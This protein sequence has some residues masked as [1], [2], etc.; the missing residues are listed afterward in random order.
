MFSTAM[1]TLMMIT[2]NSQGTDTPVESSAKSVVK[3]WRRA[4]RDRNVSALITATLAQPAGQL[5]S[6]LETVP[7]WRRLPE[8]LLN[9]LMLACALAEGAR[10]AAAVLVAKHMKEESSWQMAA[11]RLAAEQS[12]RDKRL[13]NGSAPT[14]LFQAVDV[15]DA[16]DLNYDDFAERY[17]KLGR[18]V[19]VKGW[20]LQHPEMAAVFT[21]EAL[22]KHCG[23][24]QIPMFKYSQY[25]E[26]ADNWAGLQYDKQMSLGKFVKSI[27]SSQKVNGN[28]G[29][30][31]S[32][33]FSE[34]LFQYCP[35]ALQNYSVPFMASNSLLHR[36]KQDTQQMPSLFVQAAGT[37]CALHVDDGHSHFVQ[38]QH[39]GRK[40]WTLYPFS[41]EDQDSFMSPSG[42]N[43][44]IHDGMGTL[45]WT[46]S[47]F[48]DHGTWD[49]EKSLFARAH[50]QRVE[51]DV[52]A[53]DLIF[54]PAGIPHFVNNVDNVI[55]TSI[56]YIDGTNIAGWAA[57]PGVV[58]DMGIPAIQ[59]VK[60]VAKKL[61]AYSSD[62][63][64]A[65]WNFGDKADWYKKAS[66]EL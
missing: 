18:P 27:N 64:F 60:K 29:Q 66:V 59:H 52:D 7:S 34:S 54:V 48:A 32:F 6:L 35:A 65:L 12:V 1:T 13:Q 28:V 30:K 62:V 45:M 2:V 24:R 38:V 47:R 15:V 31:E 44:I 9:Q 37:T 4:V 40:H 55:A 50:S 21:W 53:G 39:Q 5:Q 16:L 51:V 10:S 42:G 11:Q 3:T 41:Y 14:P 22:P 46:F 19:L 26:R 61:P 49:D 56:N 36:T 57:Y 33:I 58:Q 63:A 25:N 23:R 20:A 43:R 17:A 8:E